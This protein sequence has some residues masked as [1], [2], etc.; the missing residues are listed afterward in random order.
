L[1]FDQLGMSFF[2]VSFKIA[3]V[4]PHSVNLFAKYAK[5]LLHLHDG[6]QRPAMVHA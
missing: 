1:N 6:L 3:E 4:I 2:A 5:V